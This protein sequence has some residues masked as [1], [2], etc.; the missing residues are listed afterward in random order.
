MGCISLENVLDGSSVLLSCSSLSVWFQLLR[1][2][3]VPEDKYSNA[4][5]GYGTES[6]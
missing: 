5:L 4:F 1:Y 6:K 2:R 3:D